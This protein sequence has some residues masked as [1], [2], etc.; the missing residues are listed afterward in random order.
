M[1]G[2]TMMPPETH[3]CPGCGD[4]CDGPLY[5]ADC[6]QA[7]ALYEYRMLARR[8][9][10]KALAPQPLNWN[11]SMCSFYAVMALFTVG[12]WLDIFLRLTGGP[13]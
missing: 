6:R 12:I 4:R 10:E 9:M 5:C 13:R 1:S 8:A 3:L 2:L 7:D 11:W